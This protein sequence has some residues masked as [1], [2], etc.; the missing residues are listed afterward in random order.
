[1]RICHLAKYYPPARGGIETH[2]QTLARLQA[3][4]G[5]DV[6]VV[7]MD[8]RPGGRPGLNWED[9][10]G[11]RVLRVR[12]RLRL[13]H[14]QWSPELLAWLRG[15]LQ[16][17]ILH[18]HL[19]NPAMQLHWLR[20]RPPVRLIVTYHSDIIRQ[21]LLR[22]P[23][24]PLD[25]ITLANAAAILASSPNYIRHSRLLRRFAGKVMVLPLGMDLE[26]FLHPPPPA[27]AWR[28][29]LRREY[30]EPLWLFVGR[31]V[32]YKGLETALAALAF[33]PGKLL[34]VGSGPLE[35]RLRRQACRLGVSER[36]IWA[37]QIPAER[38]AGAYAA[39]TAFWFPSNA[40]SEGFGLVQIEAMASG[41]PLINTDLPGSGVN[42]VSP[43]EECGITV[44]K[45]DPAALAAAAL[46][47]WTDGELRA[48]LSAS[49]RER[50]RREFNQQAMG[51]RVL[52]CYQHALASSSGTT[53]APPV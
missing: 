23:L 34:V 29:Q 19:P 27:L 39:A 21:R 9:D 6:Q 32:Y 46:K 40:R 3:A 7:A 43:H 50:A 49:G 11:V 5:D 12:P 52:E 15:C 1:M 48:R 22:I 4:A 14:G 42:W 24:L 35:P 36:V 25:R 38:L 37:G 31:L 33:V 47:I 10:A 2:V 44:A 20:A 17:D 26:P 16:A 18:L 13:S 28:E 45:N 41:L 30:G 51:Q 8:H 53:S